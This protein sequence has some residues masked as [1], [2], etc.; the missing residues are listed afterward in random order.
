MMLAGNESS[1]L[2]TLTTVGVAIRRISVSTYAVKRLF[3]LRPT[4]QCPPVVEGKLG[5]CFFITPTPDDFLF[6]GT[7]TAVATIAG[8]NRAY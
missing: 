7:S 8:P 1:N 3:V 6:A 4:T 2:T 5:P